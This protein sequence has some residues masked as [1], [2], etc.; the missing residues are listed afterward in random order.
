MTRTVELTADVGESF[1]AWSSG[2]DAELL[3]WLT[4]AHIAC[5]FHAGD[6]DVMRRTVAAAV[7]AGVAVG[8]H[9]SYPDLVGF[10]RRA[11]DVA[12]PR[13]AD[14]VLYQVGALDA[15]A[16]V[17]GTVVRSV[18]PHGALY[19]RL[20]RDEAVAVA[21]GE[22]LRSYRPELVVV[23]AAG[24]PALG[25]LEELGLA[26]VAEGF[27]DRGYRA[28]GSLAAR[29]EPG[30]LVTDPWEAA[31]RAVSL[32]SSGTV[33]TVDGSEMRLDVRSL[34]VHGDTPGAASIAAAVRKALEEAGVEVA[35]VGA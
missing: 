30:A 28:D 12:P 22:A 19:H 27:C 24:S 3:S 29:G 33:R 8:A 35:P 7:E 34:C 11:M 15:F 1:G 2:E 25:V 17:E 23:L 5:G 31:E 32:A 9:P 6:P 14:D 4:T 18:K 21:M 10:G 13:V 20:S 26:V 16:R